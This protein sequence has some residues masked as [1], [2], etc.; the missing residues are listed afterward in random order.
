MSGKESVAFQKGYFSSPC[1][2]KWKAGGLLV[3]LCPPLRRP[4]REYFSCKITQSFSSTWFGRLWRNCHSYAWFM[5]VTFGY[6]KRRPCSRD[7]RTSIQNMRNAVHFISKDLP[8]NSNSISFLNS[9]MKPKGV[10]RVSHRHPPTSNICHFARKNGSIVY[11][12]S[13]AYWIQKYRLSIFWPFDQLLL[14]RKMSQKTL[15]PAR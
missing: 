4:W 14:P 8:M 15:W 1:S 3:P 6:L 11:F 13:A 2:P 5:L 7:F 9:R 10:W 12:C